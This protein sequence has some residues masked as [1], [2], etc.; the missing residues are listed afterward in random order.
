[1]AQEKKDFFISYT[2]ADRQWAEWIDSQLKKASYTTVIQ[3]LDFRA[4][5]LSNNCLY[6]TFRMLSF[7]AIRLFFSLLKFF[8]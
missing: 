2:F 4:G 3:A 6:L 1:M 8:L 7:Y 5:D